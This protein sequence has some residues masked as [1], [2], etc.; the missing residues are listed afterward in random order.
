MFV[1]ICNVTEIQMHNSKINAPTAE[2]MKTYK[3]YLQHKNDA[4]RFYTTL[5]HDANRNV[6]CETLN[7]VLV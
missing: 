6:K 7:E 2:N 3:T 4:S 1:I 5:G